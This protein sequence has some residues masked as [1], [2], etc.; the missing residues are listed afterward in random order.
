[1]EYWIWLAS[2]SGL[3]L[4]CQNAMLEFFGSPEAAYHAP[5]EAYT[6]IPGLNDKIRRSLRSRNLDVPRKILLDCQRKRVHILTRQD[7]SYPRR[8]LGIREPPLVLYYLGYLPDLNRQPLIGVVGTRN[9]SES[10]YRTARRIGAELSMGGGVVVTGMAAGIDTAAAW[11]ALEGGSPVIGVL[12]CG[13]DV[14]YPVSNRELYDQVCRRG[15][16]L[17]EYPPGRHPTRWTF[18][19]RNRLIS[20]LSVGVL[21]VEAPRASGSMITARNALEQGRALY[22]VPG[23]PEQPGAEGNNTLLAE[24]AGTVLRGW[25]ILREYQEQYPDTVRKPEPKPLQPRENT[26]FQ[27]GGNKKKIDNFP[28]SPY[29]DQDKNLSEGVKTVM[30]FLSGGRQRYDDV[31]AYSGLPVG[32]AIAALSALEL[33]GRLLRLP[34]DFVELKQ[35]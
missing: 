8:L 19:Q 33:D 9:C 5:D 14:I 29:I 28:T 1:M 30:A 23:D 24:G 12:G 7:A 22:A 3:S 21:V 20:G 17:S 15:C 27:P 4:R 16:L 11:G 35:P 34:G 13:V 10:G 2:C 31:L 25:D 18:P 32:D 26:P 6:A